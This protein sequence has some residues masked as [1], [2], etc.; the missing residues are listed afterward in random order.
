MMAANLIVTTELQED[1]WAVTV[2]VDPAS[3]I[4]GDIFFFENTGTPTLGPYVGVC[5]LDEYRRFS[6]WQGAVIPVF[7]NRYLR[8]SSLLLYVPVN[9]ILQPI[10]DTIV[11]R[12]QI[13]RTEYLNAAQIVTTNY[14]L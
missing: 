14:P 3:D 13:F 10:I 11:S 7:G 8:N 9:D 6:L 2:K 12:A 4:P 5:S 1:T